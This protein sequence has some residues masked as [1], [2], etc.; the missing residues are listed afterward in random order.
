VAEAAGRPKPA[1]ELATAARLAEE[2]GWLALAGQAHARRAELETDLPARVAAAEMAWS[3]TGASE[4][5]LY[6]V[7]VVAVKA[8]E[9]EEYALAVRLAERIDDARWK[10]APAVI[11]V[12]DAARAMLRQ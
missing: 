2:S 7:Y 4:E 6:A 12:R 5:G 1:Q 10:L 9:A 11:E 3:M 8:Y